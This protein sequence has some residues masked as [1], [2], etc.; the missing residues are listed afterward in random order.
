MLRQAISAQS[1]TDVGGALQD[2]LLDHLPFL[3]FR[4]LGKGAATVHTHDQH[5]MGIHRAFIGLLET[6]PIT[7]MHYG[8]EGDMTSVSLF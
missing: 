8:G 2:V 4:R 1:I 7:G 6:I 5:A 3:P